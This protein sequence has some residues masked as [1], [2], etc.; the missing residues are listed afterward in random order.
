MH[1]FMI[2]TLKSGMPAFFAL[3]AKTTGIVP[4]LICL[5]VFLSDLAQIMVVLCL[6]V[7]DRYSFKIQDM[8]RG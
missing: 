7:A 5:H 2:N 3:A 8:D 1:V 6:A 4:L